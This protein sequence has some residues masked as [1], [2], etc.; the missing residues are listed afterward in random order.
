MH[1][2]AA[3]GS[4]VLAQPLDDGVVDYRALYFQEA[5]KNKQLLQWIVQLQSNLSMRLQMSVPSTA[6]DTVMAP[7]KPATAAGAMQPSAR[8]AQRTSHGDLEQTGVGEKLTGASTCDSGTRQEHHQQTV[9]RATTTS[10]DEARRMSPEQSKSE[11]MNGHNSQGAQQ[12]RDGSVEG[13]DPSCFVSK[14]SGSSNKSTSSSPA[15]TR[16][17][18]AAQG[19]GQ[20]SAKST[21]DIAQVDLARTTCNKC[22][23]GFAFCAAFLSR[24]DFLVMPCPKCRA[25]AAIPPTSL[26]PASFR[27]EHWSQ[28]EGARQPVVL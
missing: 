17:G 10:T 20:G 25:A 9:S 27:P 7:A 21:S 4:G 15:L 5:E 2:H 23:Q 19:A 16:Q 22:G 13:A 24:H 8:E 1:T 11:H 14:S 3:V 6:S 12:G 28:H 18:S 26:A